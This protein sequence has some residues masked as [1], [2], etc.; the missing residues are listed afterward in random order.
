MAT[1]YRTL[2]AGASAS[3]SIWGDL[4]S[5]W[6]DVWGD[7]VLISSYRRVLVHNDD[8]L[9]GQGTHQRVICME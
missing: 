9:T 2:N 1:L 8:P 5:L 4:F 7:C 3:N 6:G